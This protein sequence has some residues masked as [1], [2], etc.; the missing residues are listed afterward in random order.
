MK[1]I[2]STRTFSVNACRLQP[3]RFL[4]TVGKVSQ[5]SLEKSQPIT[6]PFGFEAPIALNGNSDHSITKIFSADRRESRQ[7]QIDFE[8]QHSP[9]SDSKA[10]ENTKGKIYSPPLAYFR[11]DKALYFPNFEA[12]TL[13]H[14][15]RDFYSVLKNRVSIVRLS[16]VVT[17]EKCTESYLEEYLSDSGYDEFRQRFPNSQIL[18]INLPQS[19][20]KEFVVNLSKGHIRKLIPPSRH[21][22]YFILPHKLFSGEVKETLK[23]DNACSGYLYI[24]DETGKIRWATSGVANEEEKKI[25]WTTVR[26]LE[27]EMK[28]KN[29]A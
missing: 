9:L 14:K 25:L 3:P 27:K 24:L 26:S 21:D 18:D 1:F 7:K 5:R 17:G 22:K 10:F 2:I 12:S 13:S 29:A 11:Q 20:I 6:R 8:L 4:K 28:S 19:W 23:C 15:G 16:S